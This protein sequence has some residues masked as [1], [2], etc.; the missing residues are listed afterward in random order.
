PNML[1]ET[2]AA[3]RKHRNCCCDCAYPQCNPNPGVSRQ[4]RTRGR[5]ELLPSA[6]ETKA[7]LRD[8]VP[9][10]GAND[11]RNIRQQRDRGSGSNCENWKCVA[12]ASFRRAYHESA[13]ARGEYK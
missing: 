7:K 10:L 4:R 1:R 11:Q 9:I 2:I 13:A 8:E 6:R 12:P 5:R 3:P